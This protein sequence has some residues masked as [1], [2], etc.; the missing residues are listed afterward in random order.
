MS[1]IYR[2][3]SNCYYKDNPQKLFA[4]ITLVT[5][6]DPAKAKI[7]VNIVEYSSPKG[8]YYICENEKEMR[9]VNG[10]NAPGN[11]Q[12]GAADLNQG[13]GAKSVK[14]GAKNLLNKGKNLFKKKDN[15][16]KENAKKSSTA[17]KDDEK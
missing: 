17:K 13:G 12:G 4:H 6:A 16:P 15:Q 2:I 1:E 14:D 11:S 7:T 3:T 10:D 5:D 9:R 8:V